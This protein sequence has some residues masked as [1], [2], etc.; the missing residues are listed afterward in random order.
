MKMWLVHKTIKVRISNEIIPVKE[1]SKL[2]ET[3]KQVLGYS[4]TIQDS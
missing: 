1:F 4:V 3:E 2:R